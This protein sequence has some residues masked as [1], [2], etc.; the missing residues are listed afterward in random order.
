VSAALD[1]LE[2][3]GSADGANSGSVRYEDLDGAARP[4]TV[5]ETIDLNNW[6]R[7]G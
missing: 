2:S 5:S 4:V 6:R 1:S 7:K 3:A